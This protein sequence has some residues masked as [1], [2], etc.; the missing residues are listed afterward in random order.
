MKMNFPKCGKENAEGSEHIK[1]K[2]NKL[3]INGFALAF[4]GSVLAMPVLINLRATNRHTHIYRYLMKL[5]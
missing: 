3:A 5:L 1:I 4:M 2:V